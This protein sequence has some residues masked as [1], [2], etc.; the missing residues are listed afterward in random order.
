MGNLEV[1]LEHSRDIGAAIGILMAMYKLA[2]DEAC[3]M[4]R[5]GSQDS[6]TEVRDLALYVVAQ[7]CLPHSCTRAS[8]G[9]HAVDR[10]SRAQVASQ[11]D[12]DEKSRQFVAPGSSACVLSGA[13]D[14]V[15]QGSSRQAPG[16][17]G[18]D[19]AKVLA[20]S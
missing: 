6:N 14:A 20:G 4:L 10:T 18:P 1:A 7:G 13:I 15:D 5:K 19:R 11:A 17:P 8:S 16:S 2:R 3:E 12:R 9:E